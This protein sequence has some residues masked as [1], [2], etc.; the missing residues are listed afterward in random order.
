MNWIPS[1][2]PPRNGEAVLVWR[3][4]EPGAFKLARFY[5]DGMEMDDGNLSNMKAF[6]IQ[7]K[8]GK[9]I[10]LRAGVT[11]YLPLEL[12][13]EEKAEH[14]NKSYRR[15]YRA[16]VLHIMQMLEESGRTAVGSE[17]WFIKRFYE[18]LQNEARRIM[19][20]KKVEK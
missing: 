4:W 17:A 11:Y 9:R 1:G 10:P 12:P 15:G 20:T 2:T 6:Y 5:D 3:E 14:R 16:A 18:R 19:S 13:S 7:S 8:V